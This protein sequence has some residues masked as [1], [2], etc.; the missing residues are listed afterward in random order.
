MGTISAD[1]KGQVG[2]TGEGWGAGEGLREGEGGGW[3][4]WEREA[5]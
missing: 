3:E 4:G 2:R 1:S 5:E